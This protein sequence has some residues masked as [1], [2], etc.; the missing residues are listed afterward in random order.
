[1]KKIF[2]IAGEVSGDRIAGW[3]LKKRLAEEP[4]DVEGIGGDAA[5]AAGMHLYER[6]ESLNVVGIVEVIKHLPRILKKMGAI[7][8]HILASKI[9]EVVLVD[10]PGFNLRLAKLLKKQKPDL[11]ITYVSPPQLWAWGAWRIKGLKR[12]VD[13]VVVMYPFEVAWYRQRGLTVSWLGSPIAEQLAPYMVQEVV[14]LPVV[15]LL[16]ASRFS[17]LETM[18]PLFLA[19]MGR[20]QRM[21]PALSFVIPVPQSLCK[22]DYVHVAR[23]HSLAAICDAVHFI[24]DEQEKYSVL[25]SACVA[26]AKPGTVTLELGLLRVPTVV[27]YKTSWLSYTLARCVVQ[28]NQMSL[29]NLLTKKNICKELIQH[30]CTVDNIV[31]EVDMLVRQYLYNPEQYAAKLQRFAVLEDELCHR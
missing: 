19:A 29:P 20:L 14:K 8:A 10:F 12:F 11:T 1:M 24:T 7:A 21:H 22:D 6:F 9:D 23:T 31:H 25:R 5:V 18:L 16:P 15:A 4:Y 30:A 17:E 2:I 3:Y 13:Q 26:L 27:A 28:V